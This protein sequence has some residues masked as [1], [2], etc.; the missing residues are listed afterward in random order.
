MQG[1]YHQLSDPI[2]FQQSENGHS[3]VPPRRSVIRFPQ[4]RLS[5]FA[6]LFTF[7]LLAISTILY[8]QHHAVPNHS[9]IMDCGSS[10]EEARARGCRFES[11]NFAWT[12]SECY[13]E[14]LNALWDS[15]TWLYSRDNQGTSLISQHEILQGD[16]KWAYVT[17]NQHMSHCVLIW[18]K[19]QR[20]VILNRPADN[21]TTSFQHTNHCGQLLVQ[22]DLNHSD[23]NSI[24]YTK[25]VSCSHTWKKASGQDK[26]NAHIGGGLIG[27]D[28]NHGDSGP[29]NVQKGHE[30]EHHVQ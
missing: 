20:A 2:Q 30:S 26:W 11:H 9:E 10:P 15:K 17:L 5:L 1:S 29:G 19:Y 21:W 18:Q 25:Y 8:V 27:D 3:Y 28:G 4:S 23:F 12:P 7:I 24:L 14:E 16:I 6:G 13:D 22:W